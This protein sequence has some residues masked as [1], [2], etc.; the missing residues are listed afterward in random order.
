MPP[1]VTVCHCLIKAIFYVSASSLLFIVVFRF[2]GPGV[3]VNSAVKPASAYVHTTD[4]PSLLCD[5][6]WLLSLDA[7]GPA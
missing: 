4:L 2:W 3:G 6:I 5:S 7:T 1:H